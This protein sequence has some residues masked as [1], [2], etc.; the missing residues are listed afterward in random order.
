MEIRARRSFWRKETKEKVM[1]HF[2]K[3]IFR[4][5]KHINKKTR[6]WKDSGN[7]TWVEITCFDCDWH[8][9]GH[10][11]ESHNDPLAKDLMCG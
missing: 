3:R 8:N 1:F 2:L 10:V 9:V 5:C 7:V 4:T 6:C 11:I